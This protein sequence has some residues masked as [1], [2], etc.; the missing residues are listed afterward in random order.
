MAKVRRAEHRNAIMKVVNAH[1]IIMQKELARRLNKSDVQH[2][3]TT[4]VR[5][6]KLKRDKI[7][8][9]TAAG[10]L[11][12]QYVVYT[13]DVKYEDILKFESEMISKPFESPLKEH[14][15]YNKI[16]PDKV[17]RHG[18]IGRPRKNR[19]MVVVERP[20]KVE[21]VESAVVNNSHNMTLIDNSIVPIYDNNG[22]RI[23]NAR[24]LYK[25]LESKRQFADWIKKRIEKYGF[26]ENQDY[27]SFSQNCESGGKLHE[28][29]LTM[30][31]AK[32]IAMVENN[33][34]GK[35]IRK[36]FI[37]IEKKFQKQNELQPTNSIQAL[38][39]VVAAIEELDQRTTAIEQKFKLLAQ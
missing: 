35:Y 34:R 25:F 4:M 15:C 16:N 23:V 18:K 29:L 9:R 3:I 24:E 6:G 5:E 39:F 30:D 32:E 27:F 11:F 2:T 28:Y 22:E 21:V 13:N 37:E 20:E 7:K 33:E 14:H 36:Y 8:V 10:G 19:E 12:D 17:V 31:T 26:V 38:K 1:R